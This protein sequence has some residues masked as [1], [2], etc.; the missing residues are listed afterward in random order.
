M[1]VGS[2]QVNLRGPFFKANV[3][4]IIVEALDEGIKDGVAEG[5]RD[6]KLQLYPGHGQDT[7]RYKGS[8]HGE[9]VKSLHGVV[10]SS[11]QSGKPVIYEMWLEGVSSRNQTTR[12]KG[13]AMY[14]NTFQRL[15]TKVRGFINQRVQQVLQRLR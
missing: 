12:F 4:A 2:V 9:M 1:P 14:R 5:E 11:G 7:G 15:G 6:I 10:R 3:P 13:Y 8:V